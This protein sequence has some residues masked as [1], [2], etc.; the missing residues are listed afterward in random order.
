MLK[1]KDLKISNLVQPI[2]NKTS[3]KGIE[4]PDYRD[5]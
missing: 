4:N 2:K 3:K 1:V 5:H